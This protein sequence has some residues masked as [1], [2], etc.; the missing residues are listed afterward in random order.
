MDTKLVVFI[1]GTEEFGNSDYNSSDE[2]SL[3]FD[4]NMISDIELEL[5]KSHLS[6]KTIAWLY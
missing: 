2:E 5:G 1:N 6:E 3:T 4:S